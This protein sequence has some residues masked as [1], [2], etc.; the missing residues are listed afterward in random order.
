[1]LYPELYR[2]LERARWDMQDDVDWSR[3]DASLLSD[4]QAL[5]IKMNAITE[6]AALPATEMFLRDNVDDSDFSAFMSIWFY[7][8][9][10]HSLVL[11]EYLRRF[12]PELAPTEDELHAVR[13]PFDPAPALETLTLHFGGEIRLNHWYRC[14]AHWHTEPVIRQIYELISRDEARHAAAYLKYMRRAL[15]RHGDE[16]RLAFAKIGTLMASAN[17]AAKAIH[18]T[19]LHVNR[20]L[21]PNDT[22]QSRLPDPE[23][24]GRW[25]DSQIRFDRAW[26]NRVA[27]RILHNLSLLLERPLL[28]VK[29]LHK[30]RKQLHQSLEGAGADAAAALE[31]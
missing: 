9:Q 7:E 1:M 31:H 13:F 19:N 18:P 29:D 6:W 22:V 23:W 25:L 14:A 8:E 20:G 2:S 26:E 16:A 28:T 30:L 4:E 17:R 5:S 11:I 15:A 21:F 12:R 27:E 24:L 10:K 3:F